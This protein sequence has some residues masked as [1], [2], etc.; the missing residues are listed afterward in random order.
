MKMHDSGSR[1]QFEEGA[2]RDTAEDKPKVEYLCPYFLGALR[3]CNDLYWP[4]DMVAEFMLT[5]DV[6]HLMR[7]V[8]VWFPQGGWQDL[9]HWL[10]LGSEK[11][12]SWNWA[13]GMP[14]SRVLESLIR[15][16]LDW[17]HHEEGEDHRAAALCNIQFIVR[18]MTA[19]GYEKWRDLLDYD[20]PWRE[21][22]RQGERS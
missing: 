2:V 11:Y 21:T 9:C 4:L 5:H 3:G 15:H 22:G 17:A 6:S 20:S 14:V 19:P 18:Y 8:A 10:E 16:L 1:Q 7:I 12:D 13:R